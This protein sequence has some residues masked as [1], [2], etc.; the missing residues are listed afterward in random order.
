ML[1]IDFRLAAYASIFFLLKIFLLRNCQIGKK[2]QKFISINER[3]FTNSVQN[4]TNDIVWNEIALAH[5]LSL[6]NCGPRSAR[7]ARMRQKAGK[8]FAVTLFFLSDT[9]GS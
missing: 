6:L 9:L 5:R 1:V 3:N 7:Q 4:S 2:P 8:Q